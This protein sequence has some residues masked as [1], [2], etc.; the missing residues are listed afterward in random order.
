SIKAVP[1][2]AEPVTVNLKADPGSDKLPGDKGRFT[3]PPGNFDFDELRGEVS[4]SL[5]GQTETVPF[6]FR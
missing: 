6:A 4:A 3:S 1:P 2:G 5:N